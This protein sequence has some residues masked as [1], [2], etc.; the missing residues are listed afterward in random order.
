MSNLAFA[1]LVATPTDNQWSQVYNA[2]N[3]FASLSLSKDP[4]DEELSLH[5]IGKELFAHLESEFF[6]LEN[7][8]L[9]SIK[10]AIANSTHKV[11]SRITANLSLGYFKENILYVFIFGAGL[12]IMKREGQIGTLLEE[13]TSDPEIKS[14]SG[15]LQNNDI[16]ILQTPQFAKDMPTETIASALDLSL[17]NDIAEALSPS[18]HEKDDGEQAAIIISYHEIPKTIEDEIPTESID[19]SGLHAQK[20]D[21]KTNKEITEEM[22]EEEKET[23]THGL[24]DETRIKRPSMPPFKLPSFLQ[25][26]PALLKRSPIAGLDHR[27]KLFLSVAVIIA[28]LLIISISLT[29][30]S[31]E[32]RRTAALFQ[33]V[34]DPA[35]RSYEDGTGVQ[36]INKEFARSDFIKAEKTLKEGQSKF[37]KGSK[38]DK[39]IQ[40]LLKKVEAELGG[41]STISTKITPKEL[42]R[43]TSALLNAEKGNTDGIAYTTDKDSVNYLTSRAV[44]S[45]NSSG[46]EKD[47]ITNDKDWEKAVGLSAYQGNVYILDQKNGVLKYV[48]GSGGFGKSAYLKDKPDLNR[49]QAIAIDG[50]VWILLKDNVLKYTRG[51][52][53]G[54]KLK[55]L[56]K[57]FKS[58]TKIFTNIDT[59]NIYI[60]DNG[61]S[62]IVKLNKEGSFQTQYVADI[63]KGARD[64]DVS[65]KDGKIL[66]LSGGKIWEIT[67]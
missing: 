28:I 23:P 21:T 12:V 47:L 46:K 48:A 45:I 64:L 5:T 49:A 20:L 61:N 60:L 24:S 66:V 35:L 65:E 11:P 31:Q 56:N 7:K 41:E 3:L 63:L 37:K 51:A 50:S 16:I 52:S 34:Y 9:K 26:L 6:T 54:L 39:K 33:Q 38:E 13:S 4:E 1:K 55:G 43:S 27:K 8:N 62:R 17:P 57:P 32:E 22:E 2:G 36:S 42:S 44:I 10:E 67:L 14:S 19:L 59:E 53:D 40:E 18:M 58:P 29:K 15:I 30:K 25:T